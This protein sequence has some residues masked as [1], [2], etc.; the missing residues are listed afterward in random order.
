MSA[1]AARLNY[2]Y[3]T[4]GLN[5]NLWLCLHFMHACISRLPPVHHV[6]AE[7]CYVC[8]CSSTPTLPLGPT[9]YGVSIRISART[10]LALCLPTNVPLDFMHAWDMLQRHL[11]LGTLTTVT[12]IVKSDNSEI[13]CFRANHALA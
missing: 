3:S 7:F 11:G 4:H 1:P 10:G 6:S 5:K 9:G 12:T 8:Q 13:L 2:D